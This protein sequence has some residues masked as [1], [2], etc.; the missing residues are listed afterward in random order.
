MKKDDIKNSLS[1]IEDKLNKLLSQGVDDV[2]NYCLYEWLDEYFVTFKPF[3]LSA[4]WLDNLRR[5]IARIKSLLPNKPLNAYTTQEL[6]Q[7]LY[8]ID[9]S[10]TRCACY[11]L[12]CDVYAQAVKMG[13]VVSSPLD[14][15]RVIKHYRQKGKALTVD[16]QK[17]FLDLLQGNAR[18]P[19]YLFYLLSGCRCA[20]ALVCPPF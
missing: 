18:K 13:Y 8:K 4:S 7:A 10:Y 15:A 16:E 11:N 12:L 9:L 2:C 17:H 19:L 5:F 1:A 14:G 3:T 6:L 20:E